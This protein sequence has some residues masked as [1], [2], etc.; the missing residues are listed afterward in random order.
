M[1]KYF[2]VVIIFSA[3]TFFST[4]NYAQTKEQPKKDT[5]KVTKTV[6]PKVEKLNTVCPV[7]GEEVDDDAVIVKYK[8][9]SYQVCCKKCAVKFNNDPEKYL[10]KLEK[11]K[12]VVNPPKHNPDK[13]EK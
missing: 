5:D 9:K 3:V 13:K 4:N 2:L 1:K 10:K 7:S 8:G 11:N 12:E 6:A